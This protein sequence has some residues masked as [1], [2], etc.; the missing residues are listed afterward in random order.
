MRSDAAV[1][2]AKVLVSMKTYPS[3]RIDVRSHTNSRGNDAY[4]SSLSQNRNVS[5]RQWLI[6][7]DVNASR[8]SGR[9][10]G[11]AFL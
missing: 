9:G 4:N 1:A 5:A 8:L 7:Q 2:L 10:Y 6:A 11:K 3:K